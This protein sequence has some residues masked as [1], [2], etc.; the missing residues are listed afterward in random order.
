MQISGDLNSTLAAQTSV[1]GGASA[2]P[3][4]PVQ[5]EQG[6]T[7]VAGQ[8][9]TQHDVLSSVKNMQKNL[10]M[11]NDTSFQIDYDKDIDRV[12]V[13]YVSLES[14]QV[15]SQIPS[16]EFV[17]FEKEFVKTIGLLFDKKA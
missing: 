5:T 10:N 15:V 1:V 2:Q 7:P 13:K 6:V 4:V 16:K 14:G 11:M 8:K 17:N 9:D 12:I 3:A